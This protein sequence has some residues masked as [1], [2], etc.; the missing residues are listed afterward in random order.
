MSHVDEGALHAYLDGALDEYPVAEAERIRAHLDECPECAERL[1]GERRIRSDAHAMLGLAAPEVEVPSLEELRAYVDRTRRRR[2][3]MSRMHRLG[4]AASVVLAIGAGWMLREG[5]LQTRAL[6]VGRDR[7]PAP[8]RE[9]VADRS[10]GERAAE[11][12]SDRT[13]QLV[14]RSG[15]AADPE[16]DRTPTRETAERVE[17]TGQELAVEE[18]ANRADLPTAD[19][20]K[21]TD[22]VTEIEALP[23]ESLTAPTDLVLLE[24]SRQA[25][26]GLTGGAASDQ[27]LADRPEGAVVAA[28]DVDTTAGDATSTGAVVADSEAPA[29]S[30][31][32]ERSVDS[33]SDVAGGGAAAEP[34]AVQRRAASPVPVTSA[35]SA[36]ARPT[37]FEDVDDEAGELPSDLLLAV[38]DFEVVDVSNLGD[39]TR[40][41]GARVLQRFSDERTFEVIHLEPGVDPSI[42]SAAEAGRLEVRKET[43]TGWVLI[44]GALSLGELEELL[45]RLT[46]S[47]GR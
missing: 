37:A 2:P 42:L 13:R 27:A 26:A 25:G 36:M 40:L 20:A 34:T 3:G 43:G 17:A 14:G 24:D 33:A 10:A 6:D 29:A 41:W 39:G 30:P 18:F 22:A 23:E 21:T 19:V 45:R 47:D 5:Q 31:A 44:R 12:G 28:V 11:E 32:S 16:A 8:A 1:E 4:W 15:V 7:A 35:L 46:P 9:I 38:P